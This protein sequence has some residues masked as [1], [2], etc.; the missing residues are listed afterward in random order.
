MG[1]A[2]SVSRPQV[3]VSPDKSGS[4]VR[5]ESKVTSESTF[6]LRLYLPLSSVH[7]SVCLA[8]SRGQSC[9]SWAQGQEQRVMARQPCV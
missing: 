4:S 5:V 1:L 2:E 3:Y 6:L 7:P 8:L 9:S